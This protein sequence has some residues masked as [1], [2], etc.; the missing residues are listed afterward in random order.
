M[1]CGAGSLFAVRQS[2]GPLLIHFANTLQITATFCARVQIASGM[3]VIP[4]VPLVMPFSTVQR[5]ESS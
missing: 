3:N 2:C 4:P 1:R 5:I